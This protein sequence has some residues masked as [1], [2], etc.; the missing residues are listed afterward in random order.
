MPLAAAHA[1]TDTTG[2]RPAETGE[3]LL[4]ALVEERG[5]IPVHPYDDERVM[6]GQGTVALVVQDDGN[7]VLYRDRD[8]RAVWSSRSGRTY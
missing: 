3:A 7:V 8:G 2:L 4:A 6:A 1:P 5:L